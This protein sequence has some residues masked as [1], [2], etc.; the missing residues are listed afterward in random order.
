MKKQDTESGSMAASNTPIEERGPWNYAFIILLLV[1]LWVLTMH[2]TN[3]QFLASELEVSVIYIPT[4]L[5]GIIV[6]KLALKG[7][8]D[9]RPT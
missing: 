3:R 1:S 7:H 5:A 9:N 4:A 6:L 2:L 8:A